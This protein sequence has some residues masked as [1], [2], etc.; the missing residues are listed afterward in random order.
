MISHAQ[1]EGSEIKYLTMC[2]NRYIS[3]VVGVGWQVRKSVRRWVTLQSTS[4]CIR[5][6]SC[7]EC[8]AHGRGISVS[9][10]GRNC[11]WNR[12]SMNL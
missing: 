2:E 3:K 7:C 12:V 10:T 11:E 5:R 1:P 6:V 4:T 8:T 9:I